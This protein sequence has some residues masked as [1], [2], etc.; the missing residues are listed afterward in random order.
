MNYKKTCL[1]K[2]TITRDLIELGEKTVIFTI[3]S[4]NQRGSQINRDLKDELINKLGN[5]QL[6]TNN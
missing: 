2:S 1:E 5:L 4:R 3:Q 6:I